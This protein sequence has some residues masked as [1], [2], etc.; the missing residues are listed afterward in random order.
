MAGLW[1][2]GWAVAGGPREDLSGGPLSAFIVEVQ[3]ECLRQRQHQLLDHVLLRGG[4]K[5]VVSEKLSCAVALPINVCLREDA[6][7]AFWGHDVAEHSLG[8][9]MGGR[10]AEVFVRREVE[11]QLVHEWPPFPMGVHCYGY[12]D[13]RP[14]NQLTNGL[15]ARYLL[16]QVQ[17]LVG[18][19][20]ELPALLDLNVGFCIGHYC[21]DNISI[22][23]DF[24]FCRWHIFSFT[25]KKKFSQ[26]S[27]GTMP[28]ANWR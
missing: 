8:I 16:I 14:G 4:G 21:C 5:I 7:G 1:G 18:C 27:E 12:E 2:E 9:G 28:I 24:S 26:K 10:Y 15:L 17:D 20:H 19:P 11:E 6:R 23:L 3:C 22:L 25:E 13:D